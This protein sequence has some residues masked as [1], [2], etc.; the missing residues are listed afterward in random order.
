MENL[1][2]LR[3]GYVP[4]SNDLKRPGDRRR[5]CRYA[6]LRNLPFE[7]A[8]PSEHYDLVIVSGAGDLTVWEQYDSRA[9]VVFELI[10][11]YLAV[12]DHDLK[13]ALRGLA[14]FLTRQTRRMKWSYKRAVQ[15][16]CVRADAVICTTEEQ[17]TDILPYCQNVHI[18]LDSHAEIA[19]RVKSHYTAGTTINLV[20]EGVPGA[21]GTLAV[22]A[23]ALRALST[24]WKI[25]LHVV[26]DLRFGQFLQGKYVRRSTK[27]L[28]A[29]VLRRIPIEYYV[30]EWNVHLAPQII[31]ACDLAVIPVPINDPLYAGK[32]ENKLLFLWRMGM[33]TL[34]SATPA[35]ERAMRAAAIPMACHDSAEWA[36]RLQ[37]FM[38][39]SR[40]RQDVAEKGRAFA[41]TYFGED[42]FVRRWDAVLESVLG[43]SNTPS[44][45]AL[46]SV[47]ASASS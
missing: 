40:L 33:P 25:A 28:L 2:A 9:K 3:I 35:Y 38:A 37:T 1:R 19:G 5:F 45:R 21:V 47:P 27:D 13:G 6:Q 43:T 18:I 32:P 15:D 20:W 14:K 41:E 10:N 29:S 26:T 46:P 36:E 8:D 12:P 31:T 42:A 23:D 4:Y 34:V 7:I 16:M 24:S 44:G 30:Y 22:L 39:D 17:K 11:S